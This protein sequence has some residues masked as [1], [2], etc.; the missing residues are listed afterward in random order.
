MEWRTEKLVVAILLAAFAAV[1]SYTGIWASYGFHFVPSPRTAP[2]KKFDMK[3]MIVYASMAEYM[4]QHGRVPTTEEAENVKWSRVTKTIVTM[5]DMRFLPQPWLYGLLYTYQ[6][7]LVR[8]TFLLG[9]YSDT[10]WWYY[11]P[12]AMVTKTPLATLAAGV[13]ALALAIWMT[14]T[15]GWSPALTAAAKNWTALCTVIPPA[16]FLFSAMRSNLNLGI[17]HVLPI[18]PFIFIG[19]AVATAAAWQRWR[20]YTKIACTIL[21]VGLAVET[22]A[23]FPN[24]IPFFN[25]A[26]GGARGG[27]RILGD[28]NLDWGQDLK[29]L[30][31]W[32]QQHRGVKLYLVYFGIADPW[33]YGIEYVNFPG[34]YRFGEKKTIRGDPG[35]LAISATMLQGIYNDPGLRDAYSRLLDVEPVEVL[36]GSIYIYRWPPAGLTK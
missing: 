19:I 36:G 10:G 5:E 8:K 13:A 27:L 20:L 28:S 1:V 23:A 12:V 31:Q 21:A 26:A 15:R 25:A 6:S 33:A 32:Q 22:F 35:F 7:A 14:L 4:V 9:D 16:I 11:F 2:D 3:P 34:G 24:Y 30:A 29:L 17:R 18:Y